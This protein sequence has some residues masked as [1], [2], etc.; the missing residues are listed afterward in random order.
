GDYTISAKSDS[1]SCSSY[2][3]GFVHVSVN[4]PPDADTIYGMSAVCP[5]ETITLSDTAMGG[6]WSS[7]NTNATVTSTGIVSAI[8]SGTDT[9]KYSV[10]NTCG[11]AIAKLNVTIKDIFLPHITIHP[12]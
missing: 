4:P 5:G 12:D 8:N 3:N 10:S 7:S 1:S 6:V 9:I 11:T 2:M